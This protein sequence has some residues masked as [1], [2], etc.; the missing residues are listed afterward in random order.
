MANDL[1]NLSL[2][3]GSVVV[4]PTDTVY[5]I[6]C[7]ASDKVAVQ[8]FYKLKN[9]SSKPGTIIA[10]SADQLVS[11]G[12]KRRYLKPVEHL[13]P[14]PISVI[15]PSELQHRYLD[16]GKGTLAVRIVADKNLQKLLQATGPLLT[17]SANLPGEKPAV[18]IEEARQYFNDQVDAYYGGG[19]LSGRQPSTIVRVVDD[20]VEVLRDGAVKIDEKGEIKT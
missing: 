7:S 2:S 19:D 9:R 17:S 6:A 11:L 10:A 14:N 5:G 20:A 12:L 18:N 1:S 16:L 4:I 13:W 3:P 8:R 15:I